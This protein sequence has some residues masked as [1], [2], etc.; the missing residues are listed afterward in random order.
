[1]TANMDRRTF[2]ATATAAV[3]LPPVTVLPA[4][5]DPNPGILYAPAPCP[6]CGARTEAEAETMCRPTQDF[7]GDWSCAAGDRADAEGRLTQPT[8]ESLDAFDAWL[9]R[10]AKRQGWA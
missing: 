2:I 9:D 7:G 5:A 10:E 4:V 3:T 6:T 8:K 1:M